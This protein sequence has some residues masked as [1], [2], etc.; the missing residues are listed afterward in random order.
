M[1][2]FINYIA[3]I[4]LCITFTQCKKDFL[5]VTSPSN[6]DDQF[7][8]STPSETFKTLSW[9]YANYRQN[10]IM[11][12]YRWNDPVGSDAEMYPEE[13]SSNNMNAILRSDLLP[14]NAVSGG[15]NALY[16]TLARADKIANL[17]SQKDV[18][19]TDAASGSA[20]AWTQLYGEAITMKAFCYFNLVKHFGDVPYGYE[21]EYVTDYSLNSRFEI[22]DNLIASLKGVEPLMYKLGQGGITAERFSRTFCDALIG[23]IALFSGGYQTIRTDI[24]GLYGNVQFTKKGSEQ[25]SC[26]YARRTDYLNYY[27]IAKQYLQAAIDNKGSSTLITSDGRSYANNPFQRHFQYF[28]DLQVSPESLFEVGNIQGGQ[29]VTTS[30]YPYAFGR[31]S[32][33]GSTNAAPA[34]TFGALRIIPTFYYGEYEKGD[35]RRDPSVTVTGSNG[36]GNEKMLSFVPGNKSTGGIST[37]KW[38]ENRMSPPYVASQRNSG[39]N[40]PVLRMADVILM[41]AEVKAELGESDAVALVNQ[42]R[43]RAFG[44]ASHDIGAL[45]GDALKDAVLQ[46]RKLELAGE[47]TRRWDL[48]RSGK[49]SEKAV[50]VRQEMTTMINDIKTQGYHAFSNGNVIPAYVWTKLVNLTN[51]LTYDVSDSTNPALYPGWRGQYDYSK[52]ANGPKVNG[53]NHNVAIQGL[54]RYINPTSAEATTLQSQGYVKTNWGVDIVNNAASYD[55]NILSGITSAGDPPRYYWPIP[56]ETISKSNG[57]VSNGYG[58]PKQ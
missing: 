2:R 29:Q 54:F 13:A 42:I 53:T 38:D 43:E 39:M 12:T 31:P 4:A 55:R 8:T 21:N 49:F 33:G 3:A 50:A 48:I 30:E 1:K 56:S 47:G 6:V 18:Y 34:K 52:I 25:F 45:S 5:T 19:K 40:W 58:L 23:E 7:V 17:I 41:L 51:P 11:G 26:V 32:D 24:A 14:I 22:Y 36:D 27:K 46:E 9:C 16:T 57:K 28:A 35:K 15:F 10:C 37:N 20:T 44:N